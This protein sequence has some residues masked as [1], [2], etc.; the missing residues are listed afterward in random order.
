MQRQSIE[1]DFNDFVAFFNLK[2]KKN[3][4]QTY[5]YRFR[6]LFN[7]NVSIILK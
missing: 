4:K 1:L 3:D 5:S 7:V 2:M 6:L